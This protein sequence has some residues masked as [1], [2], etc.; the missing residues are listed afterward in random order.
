M[1]DGL[2][3]LAGK[4]ALITGG[5]RG[6]GRA[7]AL[8]FAEHG[9]DV[10]VASRKLDACEKVAAEIEARGRRALPCA[11]HVGNWQALDGLVDAAY[12][13]FGKVDILVNNA[14]L[15]PV[16]PSLDAIS[17]EL[18]DKVVA[19]NLKGP[20]RLAALVGS[21]MAAGDGG[22]IINVSSTAAVTPSPASEPYG[23]AKAGL[24]A[25]TRSLAYAFGP[26]VRV[27][28]IMPGPF[29]TDIS[30]AWDLD[31]FE[32]AAKSG[33]PLQRGG[34]PHEIVG[35]ALYFASNASSF[36]TGAVLAVDGGVQGNPKTLG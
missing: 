3:D 4:V 34:Q 24:N 23:A 28:C 20:F 11:C 10:V 13:R 26:K 6:L 5:S 30:K 19:L 21:R 33:M 12:G 27:N 17:E 14:G 7:M 9:A 31:A 25:L 35:A 8:A 29:L 32:R 18:F 2:F 22:S 15:S 1:T 16:Y 36:T